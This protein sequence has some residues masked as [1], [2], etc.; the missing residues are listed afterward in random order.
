MSRLYHTYVYYFLCVIFFDGVNE[1]I[2][3]LRQL[4]VVFIKL[5][6]KRNSVRKYN[7]L[8][9]VILFCKFAKYWI[10]IVFFYCSDLT[11]VKNDPVP[12]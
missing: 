5:K 9:A 4:K 3:V 10:G 7:E 11:T 2:F 6:K 8:I 1:N 12:V